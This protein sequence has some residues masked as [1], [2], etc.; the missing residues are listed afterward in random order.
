MNAAI[1]ML[2]LMAA[3]DEASP[4][5]IPVDGRVGLFVGSNG[6]PNGREPLQ[7]AEADARHMRRVFVELGNLSA[8]DAHLLE[9]PTADA[10]LDAIKKTPAGTRLL[11]FYYSGHA[12]SRALLLEGSELSFVELDRALASAGTELRLE[13]IDACRSG[14]MT[15]NKGATLGERLQVADERGEGRVVISSSAEWED[16]HESD[17]LGGSFFTLHMATGLRGAADDDRDGKVT[18]TEAYRYVYGRTVESTISSGAGVQHPSFNYTLSGRG[19][20]VL[21]W[22]TGQGGTIAFSDG[23]YVVVDAASGR[24]AAEVTSPN[25][26]LA[27]PAGNYRIHKRTR[28][29]V[30]SGTVVLQRGAAI[31]ADLFLRDREAH[32]RLVRKGRAEDPSFSHAVRVMAGVR[33]RVA[34][35]LDRAPMLRAG[36]ELALP[37][38]SVMPYVSGTLGA[39]LSTPRLEWSTHELGAGAIVSR[40]LDFSAFTLRGGFG[41]EAIRIS[42]SES[43]NREPARTSFGSALAAH[44]GFETRPWWDFFLLVHLEAALYV[45]RATDAAIEPAGNGEIVTRPTYRGFFGL[46]YEL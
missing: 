34:G 5:R 1:L 17:E 2:A 41:A 46:G 4:S 20:V 3:A 36:Y 33:G 8:G 15:R 29:E 38:F 35:G 13:L 28:E 22:P 9:A 27:M 12:D 31:S 6:A 25:T 23:D 21:T 11:V 16:S 26:T 32:A 45:Y 24:V 14:A 18:L 7:H 44:V 19:E 10:I 40:S 43:S 30:F 37:W 39:E 42:Q